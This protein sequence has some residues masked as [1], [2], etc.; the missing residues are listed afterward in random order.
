MNTTN[1][2]GQSIS[3]IHM[4]LMPSNPKWIFLSN[5]INQS[6]IGQLS[7]PVIMV[8]IASSDPLS[9]LDALHIFLQGF[10]ELILGFGF[11]QL[12]RVQSFPA[13]QEVDV[14]VCE[15][16]QHELLFSVDYFSGGRRESQ[17]FRVRAYSRYSVVY[18]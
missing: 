8:P 17:D 9:L 10:H 16:W 4:S 11:L 13:H 1:L 15:S 12:N 2:Q 18:D 3:Q 6:S 5:F 7:S 14:R